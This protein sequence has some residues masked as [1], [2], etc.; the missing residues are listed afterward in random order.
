[1]TLVGWYDLMTQIMNGYNKYITMAFF[2]IVILICNYL[3][4]NLT[5]AV[6]V[7]NLRKQKEDEISEC[8]DS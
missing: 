4:V 7:Y 6:M 8:I 3:L 1:M 2:I 5:L